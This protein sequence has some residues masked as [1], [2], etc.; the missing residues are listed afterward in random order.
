M[1]DHES[2]TTTDHDAIKKWILER[3]GQ[4]ATVADTAEADGGRIE[5][6][7]LRIDFPGGA[8]TELQV[9][10][11]NQFFDAFEENNLAFLHQDKLEDGSTSRFCKFVSRDD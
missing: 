6:G 1:A 9:I 8:D 10:S 7:I 11:W 4:P 5:P 3:D 2:K